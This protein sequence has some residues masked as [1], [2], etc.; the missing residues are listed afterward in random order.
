MKIPHKLLLLALTLLCLAG[1]QSR[2]E[3][4]QAY[5][6]EVTLRADTVL[7]SDAQSLQAPASTASPD[8][9]TK[10]PARQFVR[11]AD[12][13]CRVDDVPKATH[14]IETIVAQ[15]G[16]FVTYTKLNSQ[17]DG[18]ETVAISADSLLETT[19]YTVSN[20][21]ILRVPNARLDTTLRAITGLADHLDFREIK[22]DDVALQRLAAAQTRQRN[23]SYDQRLRTAIDK[24]GRRLGDINDTEENRLNH[25]QQTDEAQ[26]NDLTLADQVQFSS[27]TLNVYQRQTVQ[28]TVLPNI[29]DV[30]RYEPSFLTKAAD[31]LATGGTVLASF[32]LLLLE[33]WGIILF[34]LV[35]YALFRYVTSRF[36][37]V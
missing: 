3:A 22:A 20:S 21:M 26:I 10:L 4:G 25:Q 5:Q 8:E 11:S 12:V 35:A 7:E 24:R 9:E 28:R 37:R 33:G 30:K 32:V 23:Q 34:C 2:Q 6:A 15:H 19:R 13:K 16:G 1:C 36:K 14:R 31:A 17:T 29:T 18:T 27:V